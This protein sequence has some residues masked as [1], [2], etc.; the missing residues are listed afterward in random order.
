M[1]DTL[2]RN[3]F[4]TL[5]GINSRGKIEKKSASSSG[6]LE[7]SNVHIQICLYSVR[8]HKQVVCIKFYIIKSTTDT[9]T[10]NFLNILLGIDSR[11]EIEEKVQV[12]QGDE[13]CWEHVFSSIYQGNS[14]HGYHSR[15][16]RQP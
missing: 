8:S 5:L 15:N 14:H 6:F 4:N 12:H 3:V 10:R 9:L 7:L 13:Q 16:I 1:T 11:G 2:T